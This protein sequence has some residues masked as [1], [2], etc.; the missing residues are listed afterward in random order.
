V[1]DARF[2]AAVTVHAGLL[3]AGINRLLLPRY[4]MTPHDQRI[5]PQRM[6]AIFEG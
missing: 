4:E 5:F 3:T 2:H 6:R 1:S